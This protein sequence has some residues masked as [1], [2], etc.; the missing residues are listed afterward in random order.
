M[1]SNRNILED[2][3]VKVRQQLVT[4]FEKDDYQALKQVLD[5]LRVNIAKF[6]LDAQSWEEVKH[7]QGQ[8]HGLK[9]LHLNLKE[10]HKKSLK[11]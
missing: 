1:A 8:A 5:A 4:F 3:P 11:D 10:L 7:L 6:A 9:M 2:L